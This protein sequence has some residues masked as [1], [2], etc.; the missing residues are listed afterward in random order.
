MKQ[1]RRYRLLHG[2]GRGLIYFVILICFLLQARLYAQE[3]SQ[4][5]TLTDLKDYEQLLRVF[6]SD[7]GSVRLVTLLSPT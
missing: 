7:T 4:K 2:V 6:H 3:H 5:A 1:A